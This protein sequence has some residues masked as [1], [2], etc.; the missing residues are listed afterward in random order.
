MNM[1]YYLLLLISLTLLSC[2]KSGNNC[3]SENIIDTANL[4]LTAEKKKK[5]EAAYKQRYKEFKE[6]VPIGVYIDQM[7]KDS[8]GWKMLNYKLGELKTSHNKAEILVEIK[9]EVPLELRIN[10]QSFMVFKGIIK[11]LCRDGEWFVLDIPS[12]NHLSLNSA[13]I[14]LN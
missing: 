2:S 4:Y 12:R 14:P 6:S 9:E 10:K 13:V 3:K 7:N 5:W 8:V 11:L 1:K